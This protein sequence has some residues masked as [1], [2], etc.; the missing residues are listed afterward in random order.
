MT[1][2]NIC[3]S[4]LASDARVCK[5]CGAPQPEPPA[6]GATDP[7]NPTDLDDDGDPFRASARLGL[8]TADGTLVALSGDDAVLLGR[9]PS[10]PVS[11]LCGDNVSRRHATVRRE[12]A[13]LAIVDHSANGTFIN[14]ARIDA[15]REHPLHP[16]DRIALA[17]D[18]PFTLTVVDLDSPQAD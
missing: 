1:K 18:P 9:D 16:G 15:G 2:C 11:T 14:G 8:R 17:A 6:P 7:V 12:G 10:S 4:E 5:G 3:G 13:G